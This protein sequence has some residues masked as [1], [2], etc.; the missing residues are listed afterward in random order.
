MKAA[1]SPPAVEAACLLAHL[2]VLGFHYHHQ[3]ALYTLRRYS[4]LPL[5]RASRGLFAHVSIMCWMCPHILTYAAP[6]FASPTLSS[7]RP[8]L[9]VLRTASVMAVYAVATAVVARGGPITAAGHQVAFQV[10]LAASLLADSLAVASQTLVATV[11]AAGQ[12]PSARMVRVCPGVGNILC[13]CMFHARQLR[14]VSKQCQKCVR[15]CM[16]QQCTLAATAMA[17][18]THT[19]IPHGLPCTTHNSRAPVGPF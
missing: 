12:L 11:T 15:K 6:C 14:G 5:Q 3:A 2:H 4:S 17:I 9:L 19:C 13:L 1:R 10:W 7:C 16:Q 8:G 18:D